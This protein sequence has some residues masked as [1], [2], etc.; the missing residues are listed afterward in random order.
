MLAYVRV[1]LRQAGYGVM[2]AA[3]VYDALILL[4]VTAPRM[5]IVS[6][7]IRALGGTDTAEA[8]RERADRMEV[9]EWRRD[10]P[11]TM[12]ATQVIGCSS[13]SPRCSVRPRPM[14]VPSAYSTRNAATGSTLA[15]R[16]A[17]THAARQPATA[18]VIATAAN[19]P[20]RW[21]SS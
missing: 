6:A 19:V 15:A 3:N 16:R 18:S 14:P 7:D 2:T 21:A 17:G 20:D 8:F 10:S 5:V 4:R 13:G 1:L 12:Q 11:E 9:I